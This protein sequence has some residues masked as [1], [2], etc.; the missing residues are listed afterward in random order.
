[1]AIREMTVSEV[2]S[3][4]FAEAI[5]MEFR[6]MRL[7]TNRGPIPIIGDW[8]EGRLLESAAQPT[9]VRCSCLDRRP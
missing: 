9:H 8:I 3:W 1:M 7:R 4:W 2:G 5:H 6:G